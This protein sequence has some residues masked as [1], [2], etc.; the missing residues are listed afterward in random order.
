LPLVDH[1]QPPSVRIVIED[2]DWQG[3][4]KH[5]AATKKQ[6]HELGAPWNEI[7]RVAHHELG[8]LNILEVFFEDEAKKNA[9]L[10]ETYNTKGFT[11]LKNR[12]HLKQPVTIHQD[13]YEIKV[14][15]VRLGRERLSRTEIQGKIPGW[16]R[17]NEV[18]FER[19]IYSRNTLKLELTNKIEAIQLLQ[20]GYIVLDSKKY[21]KLEAWD[22]RWDRFQCH[23]CLKDANHTA[24]SCRN[25]GTKPSCLWCAEE[26][27]GR[28]SDCPVWGIVASKKCIH[29]KKNHC[30]TDT[31]CQDLN[32]VAE[33]KKREAKR[34]RGVYWYRKRQ[35]MDP[36]GWITVESHGRGKAIVHTTAVP[37]Q[38]SSQTTT[39]HATSTSTPATHTAVTNASSESEDD[40]TGNLVH[41]SHQFQS[42]MYSY[43]GVKPNKTQH[44][45]DSTS[46]QRSC[47][48]PG[49]DNTNYNSQPPVSDSSAAT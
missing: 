29:C 41:T 42:N 5:P 11:A 20:R 26:H 33:L 35:H 24:E 9:L 46:Q 22:R 43:Y 13:I 34:S 23:W 48:Q 30:G 39:K 38:N 2:D 45:V 40:P 37:S 7:A 36:N 16:S 10:K 4:N 14:F 3:F 27:Q 28:P 31:S 21:T 18:T 6:L 19:A 47:R 44:Q 8:R 1:E 15:D 12:F 25:R 49:V 17:I 32:V